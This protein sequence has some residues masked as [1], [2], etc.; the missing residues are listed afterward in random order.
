ME[1]HRHEERSEEPSWLS[2][3]DNLYSLVIIC[4]GYTLTELGKEKGWLL[5]LIERSFRKEN[6]FNGK[7]TTRRWKWKEFEVEVEVER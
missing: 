5:F 7:V 4:Y 1:K 3:P 6:F 2:G